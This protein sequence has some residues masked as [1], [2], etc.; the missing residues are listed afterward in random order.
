MDGETILK[1][2]LDD[3]LDEFAKID[4]FIHYNQLKH[5]FKPII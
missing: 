4:N 2:F 3:N 5:D 1:E